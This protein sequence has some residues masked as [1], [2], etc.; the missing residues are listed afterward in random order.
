MLTSTCF[1]IGSSLSTSNARPIALPARSS[2]PV[3]VTSWYSPVAPRLSGSKSPLC[4][5]IADLDRSVDLFPGVDPARATSARAASDR[6]IPENAPRKNLASRPPARR[7][8]RRRCRSGHDR[9]AGRG[10]FCGRLVSGG[11]IRVEPIG[12]DHQRVLLPRFQHR[13]QLI[14]RNQAAFNPAGIAEQR[15]SAQIRD[16]TALRLIPE[17]RLPSPGPI[18]RADGCDGTPRHGSSPPKNGCRT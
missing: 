13:A 3:S 15:E 1:W 6:A 18:R 5:L 10:M 2:S 12:V 11:A 8:S 4:F 14:S 7:W 9:P 16:P 17:R